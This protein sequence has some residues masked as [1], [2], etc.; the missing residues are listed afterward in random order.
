MKCH[1][2]RRW[3]RLTQFERIHPFLSD[4]CRSRLGHGSTPVV[5][6]SDEH[7]HVGTPV[8]LR[9]QNKAENLGIRGIT[10]CEE[11]VGLWGHWFWCHGR[12]RDDCVKA[13]RDRCGD[14]PTK[15]RS[16]V[17][18]FYVKGNVSTKQ[19]NSSGFTTI[20]PTKVV[21]WQAIMATQMCELLQVAETVVSSVELLFDT[22]FGTRGG[23][24][25]IHT[26]DRNYKCAAV[27]MNYRPECFL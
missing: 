9:A 27:S 7:I 14:L 18:L 13:E 6:T 3:A 12:S 11:N 16:T 26:P 15:N 10:C 23:R 1:V 2:S 4:L 5:R 20:N 8:D 21:T 22:V 19:R 25:S 17:G 24:H